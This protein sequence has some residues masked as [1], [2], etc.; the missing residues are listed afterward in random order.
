MALSPEL[1]SQ[2]D[3]LVQANKVV[4]FMKGNR[5]FPQCGFSAQVAKILNELVPKYETV[6]VLSDPTLREGIKEYSSWPTIPQLYVDGQ[7]VGGCDIVKE[8][9]ASGEL[10]KLL[11]VKVKEV[12]PPKITVSEKAKSALK[13]ASGESADDVL[14]L[15]I[16]DQFQ[17]ELFFG[18]KQ[19][20][21]IEV[22]AGGVR[23]FLD[24]ATAMRASGLSIDFVDT[25]D[26]GAFKL[27]NPNEP[28]RVRPMRVNELKALFDKGE[29]VELFDVRTP[30]ERE[31][32]SIEK[33]VHLDEKGEKRLLSLDKNARI[34]F[35]CH[36]GQR[37]RMAAERLL[38]EG[39]RNVYNLE[40]GIE[41]WS[42][43]VD[44]SVPRY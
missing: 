31:R 34:V 8:M 26:G 15:E 40:G 20:G 24:R 7:F 22:E 10:Q 36:H 25:P 14:R 5:H 41:A 32:A 18:S 37:S 4:L 3:G 13:D 38:R 17:H 16:S 27:E 11:G 43:Q 44:P 21:D 6:N 39:W 30:A 1:K 9:Y 19:G 35:F 42:T 2:I 29:P 28:P 23:F 12:E 33:S